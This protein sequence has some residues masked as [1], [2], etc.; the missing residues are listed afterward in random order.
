[1]EMTSFVI[2][3]V[4]GLNSAECYDPRTNAWKMVASMSTRRSSVG[5]GV[6]G[7]ECGALS[8]HLA[9]GFA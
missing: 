3:P 8:F 6:L 1:M 4:T 7:G 5:V 9:N 2:T